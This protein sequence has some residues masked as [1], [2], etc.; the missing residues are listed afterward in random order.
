ML[1]FDEEIMYNDFSV[2]CCFHMLM[3]RIDKETSMGVQDNVLKIRIKGLVFN[4]LKS[5]IRI[6]NLTCH[7]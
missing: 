3:Y 4:V 6:M 2:F 5:L 1:R 7:V